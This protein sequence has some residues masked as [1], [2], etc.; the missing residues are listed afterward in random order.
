MGVLDSPLDPPLH[1]WLLNSSS[2]FFFFFSAGCMFAF[3]S[4][5]ARSIFRYLCLLQ[6]KKIGVQ[7]FDFQYFWGFS[8]K[9]NILDGMKILCIF[10]GLS[11]SWTRFR[12][13]FYAF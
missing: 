13:H 12:G 1:F 6:K 8:E 11:E 5:H 10:L 4:L 3:N 7:N 2:F 9:N